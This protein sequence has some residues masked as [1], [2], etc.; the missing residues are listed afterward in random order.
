MLK[1]KITIITIMLIILI[2]SSIYCIPTIT[3]AKTS[4]GT[5]NSVNFVDPENNIDTSIE[6][7]KEKLIDSTVFDGKLYVASA[8]STRNNSTSQITN[9]IYI[10]AF[11]GENWFNVGD[12][13]ITRP[14]KDKIKQIAFCNRSDEL[15]IFYSAPDLLGVSKLNQSNKQWIET[16]SIADV[17]G[18]F[19]IATEE[20][21]TYITAINGDQSIAR[22][23]SFDGTN[24]IE[25][26]TYFENNGNIDEPKAAILNGKLYIGLREVGKTKISIYSY[27]NGKTEKIDC[28]INAYSFTMTIVA[29][30]TENKLYI[31]ATSTSEKDMIIYTYD[32]KK[33]STI[34]TEFEYEKH[35]P[36]MVVKSGEVYIM[37][38]MVNDK[39][40][41]YTYSKA[42]GEFIKQ[43]DD[44]DD[45]AIL[46]QAIAYNGHLYTIYK[47]FN[48]SDIRVKRKE[49]APDYFRGDIN[50]DNKVS[51]ADIILGVRGLSGITPLTVKQRSIGDVN[52]DGNFTVGD[53]IK[54]TRYLAKYIDIL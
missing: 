33:W 54:I 20:H 2:L 46:A 31:A 8:I 34:E 48:T 32:G 1:K 29:E 13:V 4:E 21:T 27:I 36:N 40:Q 14:T 41:T 50:Q 7:I 45:T 35:Y 9:K 23:Y 30:D 53:L 28:N 5:W 16:T 38:L 26:S 6:V 39:L 37:A 43:G 25:E 42:D 17:D 22:I 19:G 11:D 15:Y 49:Y 44:V 12:P 3:V 10:Q 51:T 52:D 24:L 18:K 47:D